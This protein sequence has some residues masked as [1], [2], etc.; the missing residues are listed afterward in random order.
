MR[1]PG[2]F[3]QALIA[4]LVAAVSAAPAG[5][6]PLLLPLEV[7]AA[8]SGP[9]LAIVVVPLDAPSRLTQGVL[10]LVAESAARA[11]GRF[12][13]VPTHELFEPGAASER[14]RKL[15][16]ARARMA[17][18][19]AALDEL[20]TAKGVE[21]FA[22]A[23]KQLK[24]TDTSLT[25]DDLLKAWVLKAAS[26]AMGGEASQ[27][28]QEIERILAVQPKAEFTPQ[29][30]PPELIKFVEQQRR[31]A[32]SAKGELNVRSDPS[33]A[34]VWVNGRL[35][36]QSPLRINGLLGSRHQIVVALGGYALTVSALPPGEAS[37]ELKPA[38]LRPALV[39]AIDAIAKAPQGPTR[40]QALAALGKTLKV[41]QVL[42]FLV[43]KS[44]VGEQSELTALRLDVRDGHNAA[45]ATATQA[46]D[47]PSKKLQSF[48]DGLVGS[49][50][51]RAQGNTPV[52]HFGG[53]ARSGSGKVVGIALLAVAAGLV[54]TAIGTGAIGQDRYTQFRATPQ[55]Q[56]GI[57]KGLADEA[58]AFGGVSLASLI[59]G[60]V[61]AGFGTF[62]LTSD[63]HREA[64]ADE[65]DSVRPTWAP[66]TDEPPK[67]DLKEE[68]L[69]KDEE[70]RKLKEEAARLKKEEQARSKDEAEAKK[71]VEAE[72]KKVKL[73][74]KADDVNKKA[75]EEAAAKAE[76]EKRA[77]EGKKDQ[78]HDDL[79]NY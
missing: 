66:K 54:A 39:K 27:A 1:W 63:G 78:D 57:A 34:N 18:G 48:A 56:T 47:A 31:L 3:S 79:R 23:V 19:L 61:A 73:G 65:M 4:A 40:D 7:A 69:R 37:L 50:A 71:K 15:E 51:P 11:S 72:E 64:P 59:G 76:A 36:G 14:S 30:F 22:E 16:S 38:E 17:A 77:V 42:A 28:K 41:D 53:D 52:T 13:V 10:E 74:K 29:F 6:R 45:Y 67:V 60:G 25:F 12:E 49:D 2:V 62:L 26:H 24:E 75:E 44:T 33:G 8:P 58:K 35:R 9:R 32:N 43:K 46:L 5:A 70:A 55:V 20:D 68:K 21:A